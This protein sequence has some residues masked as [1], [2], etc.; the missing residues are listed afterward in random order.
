MPRAWASQRIGKRWRAPM[1]RGDN[2]DDDA[3]DATI[4]SLRE[5]GRRSG[6]RVAPA[7]RARLIAAAS[8]TSRR[9][10]QKKTPRARRGRGARTE[11][12]R[13]RADPAQRQDHSVCL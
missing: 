9:S 1:S 6:W 8:V 11:S 13:N 3:F 10:L 5:C 4:G 7:D 2:G 12:A